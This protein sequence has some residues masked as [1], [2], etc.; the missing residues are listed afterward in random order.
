MIAEQPANKLSRE[1]T[2]SVIFEAPHNI[3]RNDTKI[4]GVMRTELRATFHVT[5]RS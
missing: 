5:I 1:E 4:G 3:A 2:S